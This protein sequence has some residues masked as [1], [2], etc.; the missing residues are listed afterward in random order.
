MLG[1]I[2]TAVIHPVLDNAAVHCFDARGHGFGKSMLAEPAGIIAIGII[3]PMLLPGGTQ[4]ETMKRVNSA[5]HAGGAIVVLDNLS[6]ELPATHYA[7]R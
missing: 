5:V 1:S 4:E 6:Q 7:S 3:P 2:L